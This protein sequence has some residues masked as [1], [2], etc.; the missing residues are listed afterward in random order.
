MF[1]AA[2][3]GDSPANC[4]S[5][6]DPPWQLWTAGGQNDTKYQNWHGTSFAAP[7]VGG[8][9]ALMLEAD[10]V[11]HGIESLSVRDVMHALANS[12][13]KLDPS[14]L[15]WDTNNGV[16]AH[17]I[18]YRYGFGAV[19]AFAAV[20]YVTDPNW[21]RVLS[22]REIDS[23]MID[24][25]LTVGPG[26]GE[27][28]WTFTVPSGVEG[29]HLRVE[30]VEL[31]LN[32]S[33]IDF[34]DGPTVNMGDLQVTLLGPDVGGQRTES[35][36]AEFRPGEEAESYDDFVFTSVRHWDESAVGTWTVTRKNQG[37]SAI[38]SHGMQIRIYGTPW[39]RGD[40]NAN[41]TTDTT[42]L[43]D[44]LQAYL[45]IE[46]GSDGKPTADYDNIP[47][48]SFPGDQDAFLV[49]WQACQR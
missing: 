3:S 35:R 2:P 9:I 26:G 28:S 33:G 4:D 21:R 49:D 5:P 19:D 12:A 39:C 27:A 25:D 7:I 46:T 38:F 20:S 32:A 23:G 40:F 34:S 43:T 47:G 24:P 22:E 17:D 30:H 31:V 18:H 10:L 48:L 1:L 14:D 44:F 45:S 16:P 37:S 13:R 15:G 41:G 6:G 11:T 42:D 36:F 29:N 8:V